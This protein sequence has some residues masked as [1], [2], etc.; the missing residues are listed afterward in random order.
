M[1]AGPDFE[2]PKNIERTLAMLSRIYAQ[3]GLL[4]LQEIIVNSKI[5]VEEASTYDNW[6]GGTYGHALY[7]TLPAQLFAFSLKQTVA[8][9]DKIQKDLNDPQKVSNEFI[10]KVSFD[11]DLEEYGD[12]RKN[13]GVL[14]SAKRTVPEDAEKRIWEAGESFRIFLSHIS[15]FKVET[16]ALK[17]RLELFGVS[18][19][20]AHMDIK[21]SKEWQRSS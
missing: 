2:L 7:L 17:K 10:E 16:A 21:P 8:L 1:S 6:N 14:V 11:L 12:W 19:F 13:S 3:E 9:Q 18:C 5:R 4:K 20:V 15:K